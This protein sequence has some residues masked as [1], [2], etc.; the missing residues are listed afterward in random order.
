MPQNQPSGRGLLS[1][2]TAWLPDQHHAAMLA[3][4]SRHILG[5]TEG[6]GLG[7]GQLV[8]THTG[9]CLK[10]Q[11]SSDG[12]TVPCAQAGDSGLLGPFQSPNWVKVCLV[13]AVFVLPVSI[14]PGV[15][16]CLGLYVGDRVLDCRFFFASLSALSFP[17]SPT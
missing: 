16:K 10:R 13:S 14:E 8:R 2:P 9:K 15:E 3:D 6:R 17:V 1:S 7:S 4:V 12:T 11:S 5:R